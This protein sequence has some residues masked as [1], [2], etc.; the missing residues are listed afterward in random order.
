MVRAIEDLIETLAETI[1][2][3]VEDGGE[4]E[5]KEISAL[6]EII[7]AYADIEW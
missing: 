3:K 4:V 7:R 6:S 5:P 2:K 1:T